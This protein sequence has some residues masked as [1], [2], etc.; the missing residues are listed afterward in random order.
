M[1]I[2]RK[3]QAAEA[4]VGRVVDTLVERLV[5]VSPRQPL[6]VVHALLEDIERQLQPAGR[7]RWV[8]PFNRMTLE[9][10]APSR[11]SRAQLAAVIGGADGLRARIAERLRPTCTLGPL[12]IRIRFRTARLPGWNRT[13]YHLELE[14]LDFATT[15]AAEA[16]P[17]RSAPS[18]ELTVTNGACQRRRFAFA[19]ERVD[20]GR[21]AE[22]VDSRQRLLRRNQV[23][24][25]EDGSDANQTVSRRH[26]HIAYQ[27]ASREYRV[28]DDNSSRGTSIVRNGTTVPVPSGARGVGL[29]SGDE[30]IVGQAR[31]K[32][33]IDSFRE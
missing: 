8:F 26:A 12:D 23:A 20:I 15:P 22:V 5:G 27:P 24:F 3:A 25:T 30:L 16:V 28:Y 33:R 31:L 4:K 21:G 11:E 32:V 29:Q 18:L 17:G 6:E 7:G 10:L 1:G 14:R 2:A 13:E 9:L 19:A